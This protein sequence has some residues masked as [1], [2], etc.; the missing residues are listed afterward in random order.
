MFLRDFDSA[1][2]RHTNIVCCTV[3]RSTGT[4]AG[5][6]VNRR[7]VGPVAAPCALPVDFLFTFSMT[8]STIQ[9]QVAVIKSAATRI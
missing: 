2:Y 7:R 4:Y 5:S 6:F 3:I 9:A 1:A 8:I